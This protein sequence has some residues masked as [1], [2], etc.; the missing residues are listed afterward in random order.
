MS[1][2]GPGTVF[3]G[4][5]QAD[6]PLHLDGVFKG[7]I[8]SAEIIVISDNARVEANI[9]APR[10]VLAGSY[11]GTMTVRERL[12]IL[13]TGR[14]AGTLV[15]RVPVL[16]IA[17][18]GLFLGEIVN[19]NHAPFMPPASQEHPLSMAPS[20]SR[21]SPDIASLYDIEA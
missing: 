17:E 14:F 16:S 8:E 5:L 18:G 7:E 3:S 6:V 4:T 12:Q 10:V 2:I 1:I 13:P 9:T 20:G 11:S 15:Q 19:E 21:A